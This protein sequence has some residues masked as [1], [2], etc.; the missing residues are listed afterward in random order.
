MALFYEGSLFDPQHLTS[1]TRYCE[2]RT[3]RQGHRSFPFIEYLCVRTESS[4][5]KY[6][7]SWIW[8]IFLTA[9]RIVGIFSSYFK[10][11]WRRRCKFIQ[12]LQV[13]VLRQLRLLRDMSN[14]SNIHIVLGRTTNRC[15]WACLV[16][17]QCCRVMSGR[18]LEEFNQTLCYSNKTKWSNLFCITGSI[19]VEIVVFYLKSHRPEPWQAKKIHS[20]SWEIS[21][22]RCK[23][24]AGSTFEIKLPIKA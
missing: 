2:S 18:Y 15:Q 6:G 10:D 14:I 16:E 1:H 24:P 9:R 4:E 23:A 22:N 20:S 5:L 12:T 21:C 8:P 11:I 3:R 19:L 17:D 7:R 13:R